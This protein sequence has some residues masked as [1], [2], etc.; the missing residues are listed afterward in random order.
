M[1]IIF[2][3]YCKGIKWDIALH[4]KTSAQ[5]V[6]KLFFYEMI[7]EY[8]LGMKC[9]LKSGSEPLVS[10]NNSCLQNKS[11]VM[12]EELESFSADQWS[13]AQRLD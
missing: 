2:A 8:I 13:K 12:F 7:S 4:L 5:G 10:L 9:C 1:K 3:G 11:L 6:G